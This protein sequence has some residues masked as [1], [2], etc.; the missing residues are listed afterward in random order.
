MSE[1]LEPVLPA[2]LDVSVAPV[3]PL[4][5]PVAP[6]VPVADASVL[7]EP[8]LPLEVEP[9]ALLVEPALPDVDMSDE[10]ELVSEL[11]RVVSRL[12]PAKPSANAA[13]P[14]ASVTFN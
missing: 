4:V 7:V 5:L 11:L 8:V 1:L 2:E 9:V 10:D 12:Q 3:L 13:R 6:V 14:A